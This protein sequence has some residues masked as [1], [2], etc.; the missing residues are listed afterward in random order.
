MKLRFEMEERAQALGAVDLYVGDGASLT[1][2]IVRRRDGRRI[3]HASIATRLD[4]RDGPAVGGLRSIFDRAA[5]AQAP[6]VAGLIGYEQ[7]P[8]RRVG[9]TSTTPE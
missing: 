8:R 7:Q 3:G 9:P 6:R 1:R 5:T 2:S 4:E